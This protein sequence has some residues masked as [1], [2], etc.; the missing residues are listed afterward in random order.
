MVKDF[1]F[2]YLNFRKISKFILLTIGFNIN[3]EVVDR[4]EPIRKPK[5][6]KS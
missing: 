2:I 3:E 5:A 6:N 1:A 4:V